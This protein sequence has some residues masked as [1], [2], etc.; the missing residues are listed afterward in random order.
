MQRGSLIAGLSLMKQA[1]GFSFRARLLNRLRKMSSRDNKLSKRG[2]KLMLLKW[3]RPRS[4]RRK[5]SRG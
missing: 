1:V 3:N 5:I 4:K 2:D